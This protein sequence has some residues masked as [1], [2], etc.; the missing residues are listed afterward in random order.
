[1]AIAVEET[2][3]P[4]RIESGEHAREVCPIVEKPDDH[5]LTLPA[6]CRRHTADTA[7]RNALL[8]LMKE[9]GSRVAIG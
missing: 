2:A 1:L 3:R 9:R 6:H 5:V 8:R 4:A 7:Q